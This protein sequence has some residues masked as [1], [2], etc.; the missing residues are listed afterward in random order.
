MKKYAHTE[1]HVTQNQPSDICD[2]H[3]TRQACVQMPS[4][5]DLSCSLRDCIVSDIMLVT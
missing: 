4:D 5:Q 1:D 2:E 3:R